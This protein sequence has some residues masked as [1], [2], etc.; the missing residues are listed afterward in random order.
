[1]QIAIGLFP[2]FTALDAIGPYQVFT[3]LPG[4]DVVVARRR[5]ACSR[6]NMGY[7][8]SMSPPRSTT[9]PHPTSSSSPAARSRTG[10]SATVTPPS[11]GSAQCIPTRCSRP[12]CAPVPCCSVPQDCS[13]DCAPR[14]IGR[15]TTR[16]APSVPLRPR[17]ASLTRAGSSRPPA[18]PPAS[19]S[20][21]PS[22]AHGRSGDGAGHPARHRVRPPTAVRRR[23]AIKGTGRDPATRARRAG[24]LTRPCAEQGVTT[25]ALR[26]MA[27]V[28]ARCVRRPRRCRHVR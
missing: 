17:T 27:C 1:M 23:C 13:T 9:F 15:P 22:S 26:T 12:R 3:Y 14:P 25:A 5:R 28:V 19:T 18:S 4:A 21:S 8:G 20:R 7:F 11:S 24:R 6:T 16:S 2:E 10:W